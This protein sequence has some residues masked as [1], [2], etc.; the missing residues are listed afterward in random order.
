MSLNLICT[1]QWWISLFSIFLFFSSYICYTDMLKEIELWVCHSDSSLVCSS[2]NSSLCLLID[3]LG[4]DLIAS[5][6]FCCTF[7]WAVLTIDSQWF[8]LPTSPVA[9]SLDSTLLLNLTYHH[10]LT[11]RFDSTPWTLWKFSGCCFSFHS[12]QVT[13]KQLGV[14]RSNGSTL[15][16]FVPVIS[17]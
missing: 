9:Y 11:F 13:G 8:L 2:S 5:I 12:C 17:D 3:M 16:I 15:L 14:K 4:L 10:H 1:V 7:H 6:Y